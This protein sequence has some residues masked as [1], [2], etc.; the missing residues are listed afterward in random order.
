LT[1]SAREAQRSPDSLCG[2]RPFKELGKQ[3][4]RWS[5][6]VAMARRLPPTHYAQSVGAKIAYQ[7]SGQGTADLVLLSGLGSHVELAWQQPRYRRFVSSLDRRCRVV[8]FDKRGTGLSDP[9]DSPPN[10][11]VR[12]ADLAAVTDAVKSARGWRA[13]LGSG[14][15]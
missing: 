12:V 15:R 6:I 5:M 3:V 1:T 11:D 9:T 10:I 13:V 14:L 7:V 4:L 2:I 8:R